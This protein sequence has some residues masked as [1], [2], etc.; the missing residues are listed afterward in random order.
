MA[1]SVK[2]RQQTRARSFLGAK[3][4]SRDGQ[5]SCRCLIRDIS[6]SGARIAISN[7]VIL[8]S[9]LFLIASSDQTMYLAKI[10]WRN[11]SQAGVQFLERHSMRNVEAIKKRYG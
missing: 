10:V 6:E 8:A 7:E 5:F 9:P 11:A 3:L 2:S 4:V 1:D